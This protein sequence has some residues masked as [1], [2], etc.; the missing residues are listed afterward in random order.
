MLYMAKR[1]QQRPGRLQ[2]AV[3]MFYGLTSW[4]SRDNM[5]ERL[6]AS[7]S[8]VDRHALRLHPRHQPDRLHPAAGRLARQFNLFGAH[9]PS[10]QIYAADTNVA[11]R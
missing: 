4:M 9:I 5:D 10:F 2:V 8:R 6:A 1:L 7:T 3:E 11:F